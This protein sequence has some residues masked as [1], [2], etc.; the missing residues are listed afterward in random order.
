[1]RLFC[2]GSWYCW[3]QTTQP[4]KFKHQK[5][6]KR[7][8]ICWKLTIKT[9]EQRLYCWLWS[10]KCLLGNYVK[11]QK[12][13]LALHPSHNSANFHVLLITVHSFQNSRG[14]KNQ[15]HV[16]KMIYKNNINKKQVNYRRLWRWNRHSIF[17]KINKMSIPLKGNWK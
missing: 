11:K 1:M 7:Y 14:P 2:W 4:T 10:G 8:E 16:S 9:P 5:N 6:R 3:N 12:M 13:Q 17:L 15:R